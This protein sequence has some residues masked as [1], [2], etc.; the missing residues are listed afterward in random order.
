MKVTEFGAFTIWAVYLR[1]QQW[2][3]E[4]IH[5][6]LGHLRRGDGETLMVPL[7]DHRHQA[8]HGESHGKTLHFR[9]KM[10]E[11]TG[12]M[13]LLQREIRC[14]LYQDAAQRAA[15]QRVQ[16]RPVF[17]PEKKVQIQIPY[18]NPLPH[19]LL[20]LH[21]VPASGKSLPGCGR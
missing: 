21:R 1:I 9:R 15:L 17:I 18:R 19:C 7:K 11:L 12:N 14:P 4:N 5:C 10:L 13:T 8:A 16:K 2:R 6:K 3:G 20:I